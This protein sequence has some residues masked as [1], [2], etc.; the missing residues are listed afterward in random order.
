MKQILTA[1]LLIVLTVSF[2]AVALTISQVNFED[3]R[4]KSDLERRSVLLAESFNETIEPNFVKKSDVYI[5]SV[6]EKFANRERF[7]GLAVFDHKEN[8]VAASS[9]LN[10]EIVKLQKVAATAMDENK[11]YGEYIN[12]QN[13]K[14]Y[15]LALPLHEDTSVVGALMVVQNA[16]FIDER[17]QDI[18]TSSFIRLIIQVILLTA[19]LFVVL[20]WFVFKPIEILAQSI[21]RNKDT[22]LDS[23]I[24][25]SAFFKPLTKEVVNLKRNLLEAR[26]AAQ[27]EARLSLERIDSPW[28][29]GRLTEF[30]KDIL[31]NRQI[32][33]VS[34][35]EPYIHSKANGKINYIF[36]ASGVVTAIEPLM[37]ACGGTWIAQASGDADKLVVDANNELMVPPNEPKYTLRRV[38]ISREQ[39]KGFYDGFSNEGL[40]PLCH[41]A[42][43]RPIFRKED[44]E[45]YK[46]VNEIFAESILNKIKGVKRPIIFIQDFHFALL[47]R[48]IHEKRPDATIGL[49]W[50]IPWVSAESFSICPWKKE[51]LFGMLG[52]DLLG[53]HTQLHCNNFIET[54]SRELESLVDYEQFK[55]TIK[56]HTSYIKPFPIS[57]AFSNNNERQEW[58]K[59]E[60]ENQHKLL[61]ELN[62]DS[63]FIGVGVDRL[64]Y[65]KGVLERLK[66]V[67]IFLKKHPEYQEKF[68]FIQIAAPTR[69]NVPRY[70]E[71]AK[72]VFNEVDRIN[73]LFKTKNWRPI[74]LLHKHLN[75][76]IINSYFQLANVCLV[77][78]LHD[79][80]NL[81]A[82]EFIA[83]R[84][85]FGG[86]LILSQFTGAS[87]ELTE[88]MIV[89]PYNG[90][91]VAD[92][93]K[94]ALE[95][96]QSEQSKR[97][98]YLRNQVRD[99]NVF[100]WSATF[101]KS[102]VNQE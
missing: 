100:R 95:M 23:P 94:S 78:S 39:E 15:L 56:N 58:T 83:A 81:V 75:H 17:I 68:T 60:L 43:A 4:L 45:M 72:E 24:L 77:T 92:A 55:I 87:K 29:S 70:Q 3:Q 80:M 42:H 9:T 101:L 38:W 13:K 52:A 61:K 73:E 47:P 19:A 63:K 59:E 46:Q 65:T 93:I 28:T 33:M 97:M 69:E 49:F 66:A 11:F 67:E 32:I 48:L 20:R 71:F 1:L 89:N 76:E 79:G 16:N 57:I 14:Y 84:H 51:I 8:V 21:H 82:K 54:V 96:S 62:I 7:A 18:W 35:R 102:L 40:W 22:N 5:Q 31:K 34:N 86:T 74:V 27:E 41:H 44:W 50:H 53:F 36:P 99:N 6:V 12:L 26:L 98:K 91:Q 2:I 90:E 85:D 88:A 64:D 25:K 37:Q 30:V 10:P